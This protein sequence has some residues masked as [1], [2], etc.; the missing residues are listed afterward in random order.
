VFFGPYTFKAKALVTQAK[1]FGAGFEVSGGSQLGEK[2][3]AF[4]SDPKKMASIAK[5]CKDMMEENIGA[6]DRT[7]A[8]FAELLPKEEK[9]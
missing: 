7:A 2:L 5:G 9:K 4:L 3:I 8:K 1:R 6:A